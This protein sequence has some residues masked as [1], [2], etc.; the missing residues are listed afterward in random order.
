[1]TLVRPR[2]APQ[3]IRGELTDGEVVVSLANGERALILNAVGDAVLELCDGT[4]T[5]EDIA[6]FVRETM[7]VSADVNVKDD[8][9]AIVTELVRAGIVEATE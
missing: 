7:A 9:E 4:R 3:M 1:M 6:S 8:V 5:I 2:I